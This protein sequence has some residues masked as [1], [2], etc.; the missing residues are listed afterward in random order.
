M[1]L[2][3]QPVPSAVGA[4]FNWQTSVTIASNV[5]G[6]NTGQARLQVDSSSFFVLL[7][8][9]GTT[10][11]DQVAGDFIAVVGAGPA[12]ARELI[13]PP[14]V[15][16]NFEVMIRY[17][18]DINLMGA[19]MPQACLCANGYRTGEQLIWPTVFPPMTIFNFEFYNVAP[20]LQL[21]GA[22][23]ARSLVIN[24]GLYGLSVPIEQ[25]SSFLASWPSYASE[26]E[27]GL[28]GWISRFT[29]IEMPAG[30]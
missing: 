16:N 4:V 27:K 15:P 18:D 3:V 9:L 22:G 23:A 14:F 25:L 24:F 8:F 17:N 1:S 20:T 5:A 26:A 11:Y 2:T 19:P 10:N 29:S 30:V 21:T 12:A 13:S 28:A 7:A 6:A